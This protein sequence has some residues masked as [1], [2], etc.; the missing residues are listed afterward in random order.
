KALMVSV[1]TTCGRL[2]SRLLLS[3]R[4]RVTNRMGSKLKSAISSKKTQIKTQMNKLRI[5]DDCS[6]AT[7]MGTD[8]IWAPT[9]SLSFQPNP[10]CVPYVE[11]TDLGALSTLP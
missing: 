1:M 4:V 9:I 7:T 6:N 5:L 2:V 3:P 11:T 8:T 10:F